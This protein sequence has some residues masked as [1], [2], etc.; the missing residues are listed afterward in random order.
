MTAFGLSGAEGGPT[1]PLLALIDNSPIGIVVLDSHHRVLMCNPAFERLFMYSQAELLGTNLDSLIAGPEVLA[2]AIAISER[3]LR[4]EKAHAFGKRRRKDGSWVDVEIYGVPLVVDGHM[5]GLYGLYHDIT[6]RKQAE[7]AVRD[8]SDRLLQLQEEERRRIAREL[9]DTTV[10][11]LAV[12]AI[13]LSRLGFALHDGAANWEPI[14][15]ESSELLDQ[16]IRELRTLSYLLHPPKLDDVGLLG[17]LSWYTKGF[18]RRSGIQ[19]SLNIPNSFPRLPRDV[20]SSLFRIVQE[21]LANIHCHSGSKSADIR[22]CVDKSTVILE[23]QDFGKGMSMGSTGNTLG[24]GIA[25]MRERVSQ[26]GGTL[27]IVTTSK[28]TI[29]TANIPL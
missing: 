17:G 8:L 24:V 7:K 25:G 23:V 20:E 1:I 18:A 13:S 4:A 6:E 28:G 9:H 3:V 27:Q 15:S 11:K 16:S 10:Q 5:V 14:L 12:V 21:C 2:E 26:L 19:V 29:V 22:M